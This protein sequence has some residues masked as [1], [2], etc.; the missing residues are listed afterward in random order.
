M[1]D[2]LN[3][4]LAH[5]AFADGSHSRHIIPGLYQAGHRVMGRGR[6]RIPTVASTMVRTCSS[7]SSLLTVTGNDVGGQ[8]QIPEIHPLLRRH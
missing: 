2:K 6:L 1:T 5:G 3:I 7:I 8:P 4:V